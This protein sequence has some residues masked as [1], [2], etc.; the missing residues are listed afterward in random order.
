MKL[1]EN[2]TKAKNKTTGVAGWL[3]LEQ[4]ILGFP[5]PYTKGTRQ[6]NRKK[7]ESNRE[8]MKGEERR[9][10]LNPGPA[11]TETSN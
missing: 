7:H 6:T 5:S 2:L 10:K 8:S 3:R 1:N 4:V 9:G 11:D